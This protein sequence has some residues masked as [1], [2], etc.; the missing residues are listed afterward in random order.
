MTKDFIRKANFQI[1]LESRYGACLITIPRRLKIH[2]DILVN[3]ACL[4][5]YN[6]IRFKKL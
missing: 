2:S 4:K 5:S 1:S 3:D 6:T